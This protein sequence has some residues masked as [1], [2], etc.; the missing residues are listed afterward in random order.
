MSAMPVVWCTD[1]NSS[2]NK[3]TAFALQGIQL[4]GN[5]SEQH[6]LAVRDLI[7][8]AA[9]GRLLLPSDGGIVLL[10][11][12]IGVGSVIIQ[13]GNNNQLKAYEQSLV[14]E[15]NKEN[16]VVVSG[17]GDD[18]I[19]QYSLHNNNQELQQHELQKNLASLT[20][21]RQLQHKYSHEHKRPDSYDTSNDILYEFLCCAKCMSEGTK[22][23]NRT[24]H[25]EKII[26]KYLGAK[27]KSKTSP[28]AVYNV[29]NKVGKRVTSKG[30]NIRRKITVSFKSEKK[31]LR[32]LPSSAMAS[33]IPVY[34]TVNKQSKLKN[35]EQRKQRLIDHPTS[36]DKNDVIATINSSVRKTSFD[37]T[38]TVSSMD[39]G[40][41]EMQNKL[42]KNAA[43]SQ[44]KTDNNEITIKIDVAD[45]TA[46][47][48]E[49]EETD[50]V[51]STSKLQSN[52]T[53]LTIPQQSR[54]RRKSYEEFKSLFSDQHAK[55]AAIPSVN[56]RLDVTSSIKSRRK[57]YE[58][59]KSVTSSCDNITTT[60]S[61]TNNSITSNINTITN[62]LVIKNNISE[63][64]GSNTSNSFLFKMKRKN[65]KRVSTKK[66]KFSNK[67]I[68]QKIDEDEK[69]LTGSTIYD[70]LRK[71]STT[72][73]TDAYKA[74]KNYDKNL[75]LFKSHCSKNNIQDFDN[76]ISCGTIYDIIQR[77]TDFYGKNFKKY[78]K[79]MTYG[80]LYEILHRKSDEGDNFER[81]RTLSEKF[82]NKQRINY[83]LIEHNKLENGSASKLLLAT[84]PETTS[85]GENNS[86]SNN[87]TCSNNSTDI[88][89]SNLNSN[90]INSI[91]SCSMKLKK[92]H[93]DI[94]QGSNNIA[95]N[96][97][98]SI[99][100]GYKTL[101]TIYD[102]LQTK[103]LDTTVTNAALI[104]P[105]ASKQSRN[106]F[107][108]RKITEEDLIVLN[109]SEKATS[110][111]LAVVEEQKT[112]DYCVPN[113]N[114]D[115]QFKKQIRI[116]RFSNILSYTPKLLNESGDKNLLKANNLIN[117]SEKKLNNI[118]EAKIDELYSRLNRISK[119]NCDNHERAKVA[120][121][122]N[123]L[124]KSNSLDML[125]S[126]NENEAL[127]VKQKPMR[128]ISV[129]TLVPKKVHQKR[130][131]RR[132]SEF[133]RGEFL[134]EKL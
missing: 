80:T 35:R 56:D 8:A 46:A 11:C 133:T 54:N 119:Q 1:P 110:K 70:I 68:N 88:N 9:E 132:L 47:A 73:V 57:S 118:L 33:K 62:E 69:D 10:D 82:S 14:K 66:T 25:P 63:D 94:V 97:Q 76:L 3:P 4:Q 91:A 23:V 51:D 115:Q 31:P 107:H 74:K 95:N 7:N 16:F 87:I 55:Q 90:S 105:V 99:S 96:N 112:T 122:E 78:D 75:E 37:S 125:S 36:E 123:K 40:F 61:N 26:E 89:N 93:H 59:F 29:S 98:L 120:E 65:S 86:I 28:D 49:E 20:K 64:N 17:V 124:Y 104:T 67:N 5:V 12:G 58:E 13:D 6:V 27:I 24:V 43:K 50:M 42:E 109:E 79:Y 84:T 81:K 127:I 45:D 71:N 111:S 113:K 52:W 18:A 32:R 117:D 38:C 39:S 114:G 131:T 41:M 121:N 72:N 92:C 108:V 128:K 103:K 129:P 85:S 134:N 21:S 77:K 19:V 30:T 15:A 2:N 44:Q 106:R 102:I 34:A 100:S 53:R 48:D 60:E 130:N 116:R 101:S 126:L 22:C 83:A